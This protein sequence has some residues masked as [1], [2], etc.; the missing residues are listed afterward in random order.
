MARL[1][2][3][4][5]SGKRSRAQNNI[6]TRGMGRHQNLVRQGFIRGFFEE[7]VTTVLNVGRS[8]YR[9]VR[10]E[11]DRILVWAKMI[12]VNDMPP[13]RKIEGATSVEEPSET[14]KHRVVV[15]RATTR[16][17]DPSER[18]RVTGKRIK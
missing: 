4:S 15:E 13:A 2:R 12:E 6:I 18:I 5:G 1:T 17:V 14:G 10:D 3:T 11:I 7:M 9:W 16:V 8:S